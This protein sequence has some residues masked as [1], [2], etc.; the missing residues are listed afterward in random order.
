MGSKVIA[1]ATGSVK[2]VFQSAT[3]ARKVMLIDMDL[4]V[5]RIIAVTLCAAHMTLSEV[6][7]ILLIHKISIM[8]HRFR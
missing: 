1:V 5:L 6:I 2:T 7:S 8:Y 4:G 3:V